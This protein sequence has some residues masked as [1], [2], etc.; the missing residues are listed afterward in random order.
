MQDFGDNEQPISI[1]MNSGSD[2]IL[3]VIL[4]EHSRSSDQLNRTLQTVTPT[5]KSLAV[6]HRNEAVRPHA[7]ASINSPVVTSA[8]LT[9]AQIRMWK[10]NEPAEK[11]NIHTLM[12]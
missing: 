8:V 2:T 9:Q 5:I 3:K 10:S 7:F 6:A 12:F 11:V 1:G 4:L